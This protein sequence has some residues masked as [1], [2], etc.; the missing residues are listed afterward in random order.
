MIIGDDL[1]QWWYL[2]PYVCVFVMIWTS[3]WVHLGAILVDWLAC[4]MQIWWYICLLI[5]NSSDCTFRHT[6]DQ[7]TCLIRECNQ[8]NRTRLQRSLNSTEAAAS[9]IGCMFCKD[10]LQFFGA[11]SITQALRIG[12]SISF[13]HFL[14]EIAGKFVDF[15]FRMQNDEY[16]EVRAT[17][18]LVILIHSYR[19]AY[20]FSTIWV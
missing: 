3:Y 12:D 14:N 11:G 2:A 19:L 5:A 4:Q 18:V 16:Q 15:L 1:L 20:I 7:R 17:Q 10:N 13:H 9:M 6:I 8:A